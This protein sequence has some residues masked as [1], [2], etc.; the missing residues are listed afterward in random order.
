MSPVEVFSRVAQ[1]ELFSMSWKQL[2]LAVKVG[3]AL[4]QCPCNSNMATLSCYVR[5]TTN[6]K[7][8][9]ISVSSSLEQQTNTFQT[10]RSVGS[11]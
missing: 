3:P 7:R 9:Q 2:V 1:T 11:K 4:Y 5:R 8:G 10:T 6:L